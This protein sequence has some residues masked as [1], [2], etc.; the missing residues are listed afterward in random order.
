MS[1]PAGLSHTHRRDGM[2]EQ[3]DL[4]DLIEAIKRSGL[5]RLNVIEKRLNEHGVMLH[6]IVL[7]IQSLENRMERVESRLSAV[8]RA[9]PWRA[10]KPP[11]PPPRIR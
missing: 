6:A 7:A 11:Q 1:Q 4:Q 5:P 2:D 9:T 8:E 10:P 3:D